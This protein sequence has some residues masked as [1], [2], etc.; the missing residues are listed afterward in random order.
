MAA[1]TEGDIDWGEGCDTELG[2]VKIPI[3]NAAPCVEPWDDA[4]DNGG[5]TTQ[6]VTAD[7]ILVVNYK[8]QPDPLQQALVEDAGANTDPDR[9]QPGRRG[10][11]RPL[12]RRLRDLRPHGRGSRSSRPAG[13][14][15]TPPPRRPTRCERSSSSRSRWSAAPT[16]P[17]GTR[18]SPPPGIVCVACGDRRERREGRRRA[19]PT[20][21]RPAWH[22]EQADIHLAEM[23]GKQ[24]VGKPAEFAG[25]EAMHD[26]GAG[27]RLDP[28]RDRDRRVQGAQRRLRGAARRA[29]TTGRSR[30]A[31]PTCST[32]RKAPT[33]R[34]RPSPA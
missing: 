14:P 22:P 13:C 27:V 32:L 29:S 30:P 15:M 10:L 12:R 18:R 25:D 21:G 19:P 8:G 3:A 20:C 23:V 26:R 11:H 16:T 28:G 17:R 34:P 1:G 5:A 7:E 6:G 33:S 4:E 2:R 9:Q 31:S 24:L